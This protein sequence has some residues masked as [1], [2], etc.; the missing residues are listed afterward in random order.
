MVKKYFVDKRE[1]MKKYNSPDTAVKSDTELLD[2]S[3]RI[4]DYVIYCHEF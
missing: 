4:K 3:N 2:V 1:L